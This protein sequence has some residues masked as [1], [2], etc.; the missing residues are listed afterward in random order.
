MALDWKTFGEA[1][2]VFYGL[3]GGKKSVPKVETPDRQ[4]EQAASDSARSEQVAKQNGNGAA[5]SKSERQPVQ[6]RN[7][8]SPLKMVRRHL[9][10]SKIAEEELSDVLKVLQLL[11][12][13]QTLATLPDKTLALV[14][15]HWE[16]VIVLV[17]ELRE[18]KAE[19]K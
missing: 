3:S 17:D 10:Q 9:E 19:G 12:S 6:P 15:E 11:D 16:T 14:S 4:P 2:R 13:N 7:S 1:I 8:A 5:D 18:R